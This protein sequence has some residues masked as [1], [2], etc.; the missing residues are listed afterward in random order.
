MEVGGRLLEAGRGQG[1]RGL[2]SGAWNM[3]YGIC[4]EGKKVGR[5]QKK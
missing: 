5:R 1:R 3:E 4:R 2:E